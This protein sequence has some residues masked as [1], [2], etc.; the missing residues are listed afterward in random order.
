MINQTGGGSGAAASGAGVDR[1]GEKEGEAEDGEEGDDD[2]AGDEDEE[3][4]AMTS[5]AK[6]PSNPGPLLGATA[7]TP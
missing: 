2:E 6:A 5:F 7:P 1:W 4:P 3:L